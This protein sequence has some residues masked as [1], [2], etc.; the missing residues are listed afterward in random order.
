M[1]MAARASEQAHRD[2]V[3]QEAEG[4]G[5]AVA[6]QGV[7]RSTALFQ[8]PALPANEKIFFLPKENL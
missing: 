5:A 8:S 7:R 4:P 6:R 1:R 3:D 2:A